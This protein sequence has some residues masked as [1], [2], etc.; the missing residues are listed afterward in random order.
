MSVRLPIKPAP[1]QL[2]RKSVRPPSPR[3]SGKGKYSM[4]DIENAV[5]VGE[6]VGKSDLY[7]FYN[8]VQFTVEW[9]FDNGKWTIRAKYD[10]PKIGRDYEA[11]D[12]LRYHA[13][14]L[15]KHAK[16]F[17]LDAHGNELTEC[18]LDGR[19]VPAATEKKPLKRAKARR[20]RTAR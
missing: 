18:D 3:S 7:G 12:T 5:A 13:H 14:E 8:S 1:G 20:A 6:A 10:L 19:E 4:R 15:A 11:E 17:V 9:T 2:R 16:I